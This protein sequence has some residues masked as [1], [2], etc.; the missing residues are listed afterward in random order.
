M[1]IRDA[2]TPCLSLPELEVVLQ[3]K[4]AVGVRGGDGRVPRVASTMH[5]CGL[6]SLGLVHAP[7][8]EDH[9]RGRR[10][11]RARD[12][13]REV[14]PAHEV[15]RRGVAAH[16]L[17]P[18]R[19]SENLVDGRHHVCRVGLACRGLLEC[20]LHD[21]DIGVDRGQA[22]LP[23]AA[24][25][26][27]AGRTHVRH[28]DPVRIGDEP[29][30]RA[31]RACRY[32]SAAPPRGRRG[33]PPCRWIPWRAPLRNFAAK[34]RPIPTCMRT[35]NPARPRKEGEEEAEGGRPRQRGWAAVESA[36]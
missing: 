14:G 29:V 4:R 12:G 20:L 30:P 33:F 3:R 32:T 10:R 35:S 27:L 9:R 26:G 22:I 13:E 28:V 6:V 25:V 24:L 8:T 11:R 23:V 7:V 1:R 34:K 15:Q 19:P 17:G 36:S 31:A 16:R 21:R 2:S 18:L 5:V